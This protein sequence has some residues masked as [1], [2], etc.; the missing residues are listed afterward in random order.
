MLAAS[1]ALLDTLNSDQRA[2]AN[3]PWGGPERETWYYIPIARAG[4]PFKDMTTAQRELAHALLRSG[5]SQRGYARADAI[6][7]LEDVL[8]E[9]ENGNASRDPSLYYVTFFGQPSPGATWAWRFEGHHLSLNFTII[10]GQHVTVTPSFFGTNPAEV[11]D[12]PKK[13]LRILGEED[14]LGRAFVKSLDPAQQRVAVIAERAPSEIITGNAK[15]IDP[16]K[17]AGLV[18]SQ[19]TPAQVTKLTELTRLYLDRYR[20]EIADE[21]WTKIVAAGIERISFAWAGGFE[22]GQGHYY[23]LQGPTFLLE[24]DNTQNRANH[25][26]TVWRDFTNDFGRDFLAEHYAKDHVAPADADAKGRR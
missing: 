21:A 12:G 5:L 23:R 6:V 13:G 3:L 20:P 16:L 25:I 10:G 15:R 7:A 18:A 17:P 2:K 4:L 8:R 11:R 26:H 19:M 1:R 22:P 24:F 14:D 9:I